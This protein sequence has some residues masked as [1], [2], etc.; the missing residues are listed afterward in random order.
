MA[1]NHVPIYKKK[2]FWV[3]AGL[4]F[5][6]IILP[7]LMKQIKP[8]PEVKTEKPTAQKDIETLI[9]E[10]EQHVVE[11]REKLKKYH[12]TY[13]MLYNLS[14]DWMILTLTVENYKTLNNKE[15]KAIYTRAN[16]LL[17][18][19]DRMRREVFA[20]L[21]EEEMLK[22]GLN[23]E[24]SVKGKNNEIL[25]IKYPLMTKALIYKMRKESDIE[26][27]AY[28]S[29][30]KKVIYTDGVTMEWEVD[31]SQIDLRK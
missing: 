14:R 9:N 8:K 10:C 6:A 20:Q 30:F 26:S 7:V 16:V 25:K 5:L 13:E 31:L 19:V 22:R 2:C 24:V 28:L 27:S 3:I 17:P 15:G 21:L 12:P 29:G 1:S 23:Y 18:I 4:I 11:Y